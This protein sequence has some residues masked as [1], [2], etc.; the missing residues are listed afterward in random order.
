[1]PT[2]VTRCGDNRARENR[3]GNGNPDIVQAGVTLTPALELSSACETMGVVMARAVGIGKVREVRDEAVTV[4]G[5]CL[6]V[7]AVDGLVE[8][9]HNNHTGATRALT[10]PLSDGAVETKG[11]GSIV[12]AFSAGV[13]EVG[14]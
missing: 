14:M 10:R 11:E 5:G 13:E 3:D 9:T 12:R 7:P 2:R 8:V 6:P 1:V 4:A